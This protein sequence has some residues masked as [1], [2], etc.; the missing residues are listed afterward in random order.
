MIHFIK[1]IPHSEKTKKLHP[2]RD[3]NNFVG[4]TA[5]NHQQRVPYL[6]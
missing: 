4:R 1:Q 2:P 6:Y 5:N 3:F